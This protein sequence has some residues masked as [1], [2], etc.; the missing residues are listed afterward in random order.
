MG[1]HAAH[2]VSLTAVN[3]R[4]AA[5]LNLKL[6][7][8]GPLACT[9]RLGPAAGLSRSF[10]G[11]HEAHPCSADSSTPDG[12]A[13]KGWRRVMQAPDVGRQAFVIVD[14]LGR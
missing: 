1:T 6:D 8:Q 10:T 7:R 12:S 2:P 3:A 5:V 9:S 11:I 14:G 4:I 13:T